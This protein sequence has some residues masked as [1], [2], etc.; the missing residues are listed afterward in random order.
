MTELKSFC[1]VNVHFAEKI[2]RARFRI[3]V[4]IGCLAHD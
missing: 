1:S 4:V 3:S 2:T